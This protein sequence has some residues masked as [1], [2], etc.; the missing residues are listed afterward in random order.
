MLI[1]TFEE[2]NKKF[3]IDKNAMYAMCKSKSKSLFIYS[4]SNY[5]L[6]NKV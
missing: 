3:G 2:F 5:I 6:Y 4:V 1:L